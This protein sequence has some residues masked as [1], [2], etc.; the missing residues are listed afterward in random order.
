MHRGCG[1]TDGEAEMVAPPT[2]RFAFAFL[3][4]GFA[5]LHPRLPECR[6]YAPQGGL[7]V[8][9]VSRRVPALCLLSFGA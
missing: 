6:R 2:R 9:I 7:T 1:A 3:S 5:R 8:E 4:V